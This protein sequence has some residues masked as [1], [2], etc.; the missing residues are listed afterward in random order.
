MAII[1]RLAVQGD[2][3]MLTNADCTLYLYD[4]S[5]GGYHRYFIE[6]VYWNENKAG[7][8]LKSG[9]VSAD[10]VAVYLYSDFVVPKNPTFDMI[11]KGSCPFEFDNTNEKTISDSVR[12]FKK[13]YDSFTIMSCDNKMFGGLPHIELSAK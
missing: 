9:L 8:V 3:I 11:V 13:E 7:N 6:G 5:T 1:H 12:K 10:S 4:K 2:F